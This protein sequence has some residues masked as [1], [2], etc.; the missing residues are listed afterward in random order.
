MEKFKIVALINYDRFS[1]ILNSSDE[2]IIIYSF[3]LLNEMQVF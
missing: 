3:D 2:K 1:Y